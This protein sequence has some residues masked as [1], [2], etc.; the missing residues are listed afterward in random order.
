MAQNPG[1]P[2]NT[3]AASNC[4]ADIASC[5]KLVA[6]GWLVEVRWMT[7]FGATLP[8]PERSTNAE[9]CAKAGLADR[10]RNRPG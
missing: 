6:F 5:Y 2:S 8:L 1:S 7:G 9:D 4:A 10:I 3:I